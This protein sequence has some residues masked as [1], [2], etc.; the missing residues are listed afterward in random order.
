MREPLLQMEFFETYY[1]AN[2][3]HNV[4][5]DT[6]PYLR[7]LNNWHEDREVS[8]FLRPFPKWSVLHDFAQYVIEDLIYERLESS[9]IEAIQNNPRSILWIDQALAHHKIETSGFRAWLKQQEIEIAETSQDVIYDYH[10]DLRLTGEF[11]K[12]L[13]QLT[14]EVFYLVF[15]NRTLLAKLN[16]YASG[17]VQG[18]THDDLA[19]EDHH[20]LH[21]DGV[22]A[23]THIP[24][25][26]RRA[27]FFRDRGMCASCN[28]DLTGIIAVNSSEHYDHIIPLAEGGINDVTNLQLLCAACN[29]KKGRLLLPTSKRYQSWYATED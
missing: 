24:E 2:V 23:R 10:N 29:L 4:L 19:P 12:L 20:L 17:V 5:N 9:S 25:W 27:I 13:T 28:T 21:K 1:Y 3:V 6:T 22:P 11:D 15:G 16:S 26:A 14:S 7:N 18:L 8:L